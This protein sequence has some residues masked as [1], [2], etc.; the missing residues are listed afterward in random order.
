MSF[1]ELFLSH[2]GGIENNCLSDILDMHNDEVNEFQIIRRSSYYDYD[3][4]ND[5]AKENKDRFNIYVQTYNLLIQSL[6][7]LS[8][9]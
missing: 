1:D 4:F 8:F 3:K 7:S 9:F 2:L 6:V 5:F